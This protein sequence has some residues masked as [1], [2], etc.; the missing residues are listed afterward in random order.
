MVQ[1]KKAPLPALGY[2]RALSLSTQTFHPSF[3]QHTCTQ[4]YAKSNCIS[5]HW[6]DPC[7]HVTHLSNLW[8]L[9]YL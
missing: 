5:H 7:G 6:L 4:P 8:N 1:K 9:D 3:E 2:K